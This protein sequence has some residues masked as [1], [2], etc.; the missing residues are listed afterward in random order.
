MNNR[1][2]RVRITVQL[3]TQCESAHRR[4][5]KFTHG[6][7]TVTE[8][9]I[10]IISQVFLLREAVINTE[11]DKDK[12]INTLPLFQITSSQK[13]IEANVNYVANGYRVNVTFRWKI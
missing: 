8:P 10:S 7:Q 1:E 9:L 4:A 11:N 3:V 6:L 2:Q 5:M 12:L 13:R